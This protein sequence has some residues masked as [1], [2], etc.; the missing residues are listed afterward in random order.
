MKWGG[1]DHIG[2][3]R[4]WQVLVLPGDVAWSFV[5]KPEGDGWS[6]RGLEYD[7]KGEGFH[8]IDHARRHIER[9]FHEQQDQPQT[10][11]PVQAQ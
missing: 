3:G 7:L 2:D 1:E 8:T 9:H 11:G 6:F 10:Q 5:F 4:V